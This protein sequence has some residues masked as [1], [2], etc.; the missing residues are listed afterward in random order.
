MD[1][2]QKIEPNWLQAILKPTSIK[3]LDY[4]HIL[5]FNKFSNCTRKILKLNFIL[6]L[7]FEL[8]NGEKS[9]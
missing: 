8:Q 4:I 5:K 3:E 7:H 6:L 2:K 9:A 1:N